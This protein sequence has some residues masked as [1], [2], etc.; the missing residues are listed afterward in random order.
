M[1]TKITDLKVSDTTAKFIS[2][3]ALLVKAKEEFLDA[4]VE[5]YGEETGEKFY[6][7]S[8]PVFEETRLKIADFLTMSIDDNENGRQGI[9]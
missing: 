1:S 9:I 5:L 6:S 2:S 7:D 4:L 3:L 8:L